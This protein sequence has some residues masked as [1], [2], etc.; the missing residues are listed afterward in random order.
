VAFDSSGN[1]RDAKYLNVPREGRA[2]A[3]VDDPDTAVRFDGL[4]DCAQWRTGSGYSG[5]FSAEARVRSAV[6]GVQVAGQ[7]DDRLRLEEGSLV[8]HRGR[9]FP[10][11]RHD[12]TTERPSERSPSS[13][14]GPPLLFDASHRKLQ[15]P[16]SKPPSRSSSGP[17]G[18]RM[19]PSSVMNV[20]MVRCPWVRSLLESSALVRYVG[21][22]RPS[23]LI[24]SREARRARPEEM[25]VRWQR[26]SR[27]GISVAP[28][29]GA[30]I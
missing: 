26:S 4:N 30:S 19:I 18:A 28:S 20:A 22:R 25:E 23:D 7:L 24:G 2:G 14:D 16:C 12:T 21:L 15:P 5:T 13:L 27:V 17:P 6:R 3:I 8:S 10:V 29:S 1:E 11:E 9:G